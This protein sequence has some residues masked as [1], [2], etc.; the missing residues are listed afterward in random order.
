MAAKRSEAMRTGPCGRTRDYGLG[1]AIL[2]PKSGPIPN[3]GAANP[4]DRPG[5][6]D[7]SAPIGQGTIGRTTREGRPAS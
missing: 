2:Q 4:C 7:R 6:R 1:P 5:R 3:R